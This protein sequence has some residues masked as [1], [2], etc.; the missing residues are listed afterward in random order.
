MMHYGISQSDVKGWLILA[1]ITGKERKLATAKNGEVHRAQLADRLEKTIIRRE[2]DAVVLD[3]FIKSH[4]VSENDNA[5]ID[6]VA[7]ILAQIAIEHDC[8]VD[9]PH[10][11]NKLPTDPGNANSARGASSFKDAGRLT[12]HAAPMTPDEAQTFGVPEEERRRLVRVDSGKV[13]TV[14]ASTSAKWFQLVSVNIGNGTTQYRPAT[15][16]K[17]PNPGR[18]QTCGATCRCRCA[19]EYSTRSTPACR[20]TSS[21]TRRRSTA[22]SVAASAGSNS[23]RRWCRAD[24]ETLHARK[25]PLG[26]PFDV[27]IV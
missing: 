17:S 19:T 24:A 12:L 3:P 22:S 18:R 2:I 20:T 6:Q 9:A 8:A 13:N 11:T 23:T 15:T 1:S 5:E 4:G 7:A 21:R 14:P 27:M 25:Q 10:H 26:E 16:C